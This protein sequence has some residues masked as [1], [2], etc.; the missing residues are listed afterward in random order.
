MAANHKCTFEVLKHKGQ[1]T[2]TKTANLSTFSTYY[3]LYINERANIFP[4]YVSL[5]CRATP[6]AHKHLVQTM[7]GTILLY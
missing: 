6:K 3:V 7:H 5:F 1:T 4:T 2:K